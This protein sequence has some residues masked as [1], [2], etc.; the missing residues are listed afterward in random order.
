MD[1]QIA[2]NFETLQERCK[3]TSAMLESLT[4][5][6]SKIAAQPTP[7]TTTG[8]GPEVHC[9]ETPQA[10]RRPEPQV[11]SQYERPVRLFAAPYV[12][13]FGEDLTE[14]APQPTEQPRPPPRQPDGRYMAPELAA[15][16]PTNVQQ[17]CRYP[18][19]PNGR[20]C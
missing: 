7:A 16:Y 19:M 1:G 12:R 3:L 6:V 4:D 5:T 18:P 20:S 2:A 13:R 15:S 17:Q 9:M 14:S 8:Q 11:Q 10:F